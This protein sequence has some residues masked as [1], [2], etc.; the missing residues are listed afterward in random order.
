MTKKK[1]ASKTIHSNQFH[2]NM[3]ISVN[4]WKTRFCAK[5]MFRTDFLLLII[6][7]FS[8]IIA[9]S[10]PRLLPSHPASP[11][12]CQGRGYQLRHGF[13][14]E[15]SGSAKCSVK[16]TGQVLKQGWGA[17]VGVVSVGIPFP[18][19]VLYTFKEYQLEW[20]LYFILPAPT[21]TNSS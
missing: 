14:S 12:Q 3:V 11:V 16:V 2:I 7:I 6:N 9:V 8:Y 21:V 10:R 4:L 17:N 15:K 18:L 20:K 1:C 19:C 5:H 13:G